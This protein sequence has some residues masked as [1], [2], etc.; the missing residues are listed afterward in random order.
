[1][2]VMVMGAGGVGGYL[3]AKLAHA[4]AAVSFIA[5]GAHL[6]QM[7]SYGL[8]V[9]GS[10]SIHVREFQA[11]DNVGEL[12]AP[13]LVLF[14]VKL[15]DTVDAAKLIAPVLSERTAVLTLQNGID[16]VPDLQRL[17]GVRQVLGGA[18]FF[19]ANISAPGVVRYLGKIESKPHIEFGEPGAGPSERVSA[20][21]SVLLQAGLT[22]EVCSDTNRMLWEK[23]LLIAGTSAATTLSRSAIGVIRDDADLRWLLRA[24]IDEA[25]RVGCAAGVRLADDAVAQVV[26]TLNGNPDDAKASQLVDLENGRCL[27]LDGL[28]GAI[29]RHGQMLGVDTPIHRCVYA[30]LKPFM[31]GTQGTVFTS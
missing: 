3:G 27:E 29:V 11:A 14:C 19:P 4:G 13:D 1:M 24:S 26:R 2:N 12:P 17:L 18:A 8:R 28:S 31:H 30:A 21:A 5:R 15:Y 22:V 7:R 20:I 6:A 10:E 16:S 23:F 9:E 25:Y